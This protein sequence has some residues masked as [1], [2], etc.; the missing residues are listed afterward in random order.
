[1]VAEVISYPCHLWQ[2][3]VVPSRCLRSH[4]S[5]AYHLHYPASSLTESSKLGMQR[6][7]ETGLDLWV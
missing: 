5:P 1:M 7:V 3:Q 2:V 6:T 4:Y